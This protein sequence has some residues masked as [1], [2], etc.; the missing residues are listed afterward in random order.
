MKTIIIPI[1]FSPAANNA[2]LYAAE[3]LKDMKAEKVILLKNFYKSLY[4]QLLPTPDFVQISNEDIQEE[5]IKIQ[6]QLDYLKD[7]YFSAAGS[8]VHIETKISDL[9]LLRSI[10]VI[11]A[12]EKPDLI[13]IGSDSKKHINESYISARAI[14]ITKTSTVPVLV[15][16]VETAYRKVQRVVIPCDFSAVSRLKS[17]SGIN[18]AL[19][20]MQPELM[21]LNVDPK[22]EHLTRGDEDAD[23]LKEVLKGR[24]HQVY[25]TE[26]RDTVNGILNF[27]AD[28]DSELIIALPGRYSFFYNLT[29]NSITDALSVNA[30]RPILIMK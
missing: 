3:L 9:P 27:A 8:G 23:A 7:H 20:L 17:I 19:D 21:I 1:D 29:H 2:L 25:Y 5:K 12:Q 14:E 16:P 11:N 13:I 28:H 6:A 24:A 18:E 26:D 30:Q 10:Q 22:H 15:V 4:E